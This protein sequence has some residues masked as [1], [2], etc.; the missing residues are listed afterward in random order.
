VN[1]R[2]VLPV[3]VVSSMLMAGLMGLA[4]PAS[5]VPPAV[6]T[7]SGDAS[8]FTMTPTS[9]DLSVGDSFDI[10][11]EITA[12]AGDVYIVGAITRTV[13]PRDCSTF[14]VLT[15]GSSAAYVIDATSD[16]SIYEYPG[17]APGPLIGTLTFGGGAPVVDPSTYPRVTFDPNDGACTGDL[18]LANDGTSNTQ[19][20]MLTSSRCSRAGF[21]L[22][23]WATS[24]SATSASYQPGFL[25]DLTESLTVY[26][27]WTPVGVAVTYD[28]NVGM[29]TACL[30]AT[31][32]NETT[33]AA[34]TSGPT[35]LT[36]T[37]ASATTAPC[38]PTGFRLQ[39]WT[40]TPGAT[41]FIA[42]GAAVGGTTGTSFTL[43]AKWLGVGHC[44][45]PASNGVDWHNCDK[46]GA[47]LTSAQLRGANLSGAVLVKATLDGAMLQG[48]NLSGANLTDASLKPFGS[49]G[50]ESRTWLENANMA[51][52]VLVRAK[53]DG[54]MLQGANLSGADL[55]DASLKRVGSSPNTITTWLQDANLS[56]ANLSRANLANA[57]M[58]GAILT[59]SILTGTNMTGVIK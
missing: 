49:R 38:T 33:A 34:R 47:N 56:D 10:S 14:C 37:S 2:R 17:G 36:P 48:A 40:R 45:A 16:V 54:A 51:G 59:G 11:D 42:P 50:H 29:E 24:A 43:F 28:A 52:A 5:A 1:V 22:A 55:T 57:Y 18:T 12:V 46:A 58:A 25:A 39:G 26:A 35:A 53:L 8:P 41:E 7:V 13:D 6:V 19:Y 3:V 30:N 21:T 32:A 44:S 9:L 15:K 23:G 27:V 4:S 31:G 20:S